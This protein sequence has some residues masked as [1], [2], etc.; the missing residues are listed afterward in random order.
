MRFARFHTPEGAHVALVDGDGCTLVDLTAA[1]PAFGDDP[2]PI[3]AAGDDGRRAAAA[4]A[5]RVDP[6]ERIDVADVR[7][8]APVSRPPRFLGIG[9]NYR[10]HEADAGATPPGFPLFFNKQTTCLTGPG[11]PIMSPPTSDQVDYE[12]ELVLV[13]GRRCR[14]VTADRASEVVA[15]VTVGN[16]VSARDWQ[17][18]SPTVT[19]GKSFD[20]TAPLGPWITTLDEIAD[21][22]D[23]RIRTWVNDELVQDGCTADMITTCWEQVALLS[24]VFT[25]LPGDLIST[26]TPPGAAQQQPDPRWLRI[27]DRVR[28]RIDGL[29]EIDNTVAAGSTATTIDAPAPWPP[30]GTARPT[31]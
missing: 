3:L 29:G 4:A 16:D 22:A 24:S 19:L 28:V 27:G 12:G 2:V 10:G 18:R 17:R 14:N 20:R 6:G 23:L 1:D 26:G 15:G 31:R 8:L 25:L 7:L 5:A 30:D 9:F 21:V 11:D 13:I